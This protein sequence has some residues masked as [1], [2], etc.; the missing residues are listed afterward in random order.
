M[1]AVRGQTAYILD[2]G[3]A[4]CR[5]GDW[6]RG[7][8]H[9]GRL[10]EG[11]EGAERSSLPGLFYS[12]LGYG[13]ARC[14]Q[15]VQEGVKLCRHAIK[16]EFYQPENYLNLARTLLLLND[17]QG[18]V[19][20][21]Q[22]GL[23]IDPHQPQLVEL[24]RELGIRRRPVLPFLSRTNPLNRFLG[25]LRHTLDRPVPSLRSAASRVPG[26]GPAGGSPAAE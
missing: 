17:R 9:L 10:A 18:A 26:R 4:L 20:A 13:V 14:E 22:R 5:Q 15:R 23:K 25:S 2:R 1:A 8:L 24:S 3:L 16:V 11:M 12:F 19:S 6:Q 21:V 7:L